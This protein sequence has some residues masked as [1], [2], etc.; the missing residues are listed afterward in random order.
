MPVPNDTIFGIDDETYERITYGDVRKITDENKL[1]RLLQLRLD[2]FL[3]KQTEPITTSFPLICMSCVAIETLGQI[4]YKD[5]KDDTSFRFTSVVGKFSQNFTRKFDADFKKRLGDLW[6]E[7]KEISKINTLASLIYTYLRNTMIH[8]FQGRGVY[9]SF[10]DTTCFI[11]TDGYLVLNPNWFWGKTKN[12]YHDLF[13][14][15]LKGQ[16]TTQERINCL[17][18][19]RKMIA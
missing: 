15:A 7:N 12:A 11:K 6:V 14:T 18:Y 5:N 19:I 3:F 8:G 2:T 16:K 10:E 13:S 9:L 1:I 17:T 4:F